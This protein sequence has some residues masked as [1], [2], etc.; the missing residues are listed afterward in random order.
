MAEKLTLAQLAN[1]TLDRV[2]IDS[3][4][5]S[6]YQAAMVTADQTERPLWLTEQQRLRCRN[7]TEIRELLAALTINRLYLRQNSPY[8]EMVGQPH[9]DAPNTLLIELEQ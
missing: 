7:L 6:I 2:V 9:R 5:G 1:V 3:F 8:D 4:E